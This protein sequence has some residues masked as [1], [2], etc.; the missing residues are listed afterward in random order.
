MDQ[1]LN[2]LCSE[3]EREDSEMNEQKLEHCERCHSALKS[4][5]YVFDPKI[6]KVRYSPP[7]RCNT[8][9]ST[10]YQAGEVVSAYLPNEDEGLLCKCK[11]PGCEK[12]FYNRP[13]WYKKQQETA[14]AT[15]NPWMPVLIEK[16]QAKIDRLLS[17]QETTSV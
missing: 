17:D 7:R 3:I 5:T 9:K 2:A 8:C 4:D 6:P 1:E 12:E 16:D 13:S 14:N 10:N 11:F 15:G